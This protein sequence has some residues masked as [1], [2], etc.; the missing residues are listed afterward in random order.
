MTATTHTKPLNL[1]LPEALDRVAQLRPQIAAGA[2]AGESDRKMPAQLHRALEDAGLFALLVP[3]HYGGAEMHP[4]D[5][6]RVWEAVAR[7]DPT[8]G[9][10]LVMNGSLSAMA[11]WLPEAGADELFGAGPT[12]TAGAL[13]PPGVIVRVDGGWRLTGQVPFTSGC[14]HARWFILPGMEMDGDGPKLDPTTGQPTPYVCFVHRDDATVIDT[15]HTMGMRGTGSADVAVQDVFVPDHR[16]YPVA[17]LV[18]PNPGFDGPVARMFPLLTV[19]GEAII[20]VGAAATAVDILIGLA[21]RKTPAYT[22]VALRDR[23][24]AQYQAGRARGLVDASRATLF[25]ACAVAYGEASQ[26]KALSP[27]TKIRCQVAASFA[28]EACAEAGRMVHAAAGSS[29]IRNELGL[30]RLF[31]DLHT[32]TQHGS[33]SAPRYGSAGRLMFGLENDWIFL[34]F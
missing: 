26:G 27:D 15:W 21:Q 34:A 32:L 10:L 22:M 28:A 13:H 8:A 3:R 12:T 31:R 1:T 7:I 16:C 24:L 18:T 19:M 9:W 6:Y 5:V 4:L 29:G 25:D 17:P 14:D 33:K 11:A 20:S 2:T 30:E 23:E